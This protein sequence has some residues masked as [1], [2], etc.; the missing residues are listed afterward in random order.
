MKVRGCIGIHAGH[1]IG[2]KRTLQAAHSIVAT[3]G[4]GDKTS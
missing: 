3:A 2:T 1:E 4:T